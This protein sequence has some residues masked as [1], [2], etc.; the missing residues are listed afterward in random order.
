MLSQY[1]IIPSVGHLHQSLNLFASLRKHSCSKDVLHPC[2]SEHG[3]GKFYQVYWY[4]LYPDTKKNIPRDAPPKRGAF[5]T[6][7]LFVNSDHFRY[8]LKVPTR[9]SQYLVIEH[10]L[11]GTLRGI[12][13]LKPQHSSHSLFL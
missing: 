13:L 11:S 12:I 10:Q 7:Q 3:G 5:C 4:N 2:M 6:T 9:E 1:F 8:F